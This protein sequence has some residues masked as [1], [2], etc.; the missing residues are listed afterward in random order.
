[1]ESSESPPVRG[2]GLKCYIPMSV[3]AIVKGCGVSRFTLVA[4]GDIEKPESRVIAFTAFGTED[5]REMVSGG[6][7]NKIFMGLNNVFL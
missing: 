4:G 6:T 3:Q 7:R 2:R 5:S 1:M